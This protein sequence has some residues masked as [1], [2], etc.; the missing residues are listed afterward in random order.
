[1]TN[2][3]NNDYLY[4]AKRLLVTLEKDDKQPI[5]LQGTGFF[6]KKGDTLILVTNRHMVEPWVFDDTCNG[7]RVIA[8]EVESFQSLDEHGRPADLK[9]VSVENFKDFVFSENKTDDVACLINPKG[10]PF[11][12]DKW[13]PYEFLVDDDWINKYVNV[14]DTIAYPGFPV[15]HNKTNDS[16]IFKMGTIASDPRYDY[17]ED[18][19][20]KSS[21]RIAYEGF[22]SSGM[23]GSPVFL[24]QRGMKLGDGLKYG[25]N[26]FYREVKIIG[27][28]AGHFKDRNLI[29]LNQDPEITFSGTQHAGLSYFYRSSII[30]DII[31]RNLE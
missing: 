25:N 6:V 4:A 26:A 11:S 18:N 21:G 9:R 16:P 27:I 2:G 14:C 24:T 19:K 13:I 17:N 30:K 23:S 10:G 31:D 22:S 1:M 12:V 5:K 7:C 29:S 8:Y 20:N 15:L 3:I 28:N